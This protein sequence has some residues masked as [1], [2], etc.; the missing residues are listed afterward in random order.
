MSNWRELQLNL[1]LTYSRMRAESVTSGKS[2]TS[3]RD[4]YRVKSKTSDVDETLFA[5]PTKRK[6]HAPPKKETVQVSTFGTHPKGRLF[7]ITGNWPFQTNRFFFDDIIQRFMSFLG[8]YKRSYTK[9]DRTIKRS[10]RSIYCSSSTQFEQ[11]QISIKSQITVRNRARSNETST[12]ERYS[13]L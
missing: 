8:D 9:C 1:T 3:T 5:S 6:T 13:L 2:R 10:I 7:I 4:R 11:N 12:G